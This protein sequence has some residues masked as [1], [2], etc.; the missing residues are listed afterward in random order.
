M[1]KKTQMGVYGGPDS[2]HGVIARRQ[3]DAELG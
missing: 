3:A 1:Q 2:N